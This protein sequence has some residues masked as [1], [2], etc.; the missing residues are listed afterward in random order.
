MIESAED[1][2]SV[3][4]MAI[5]SRNSCASAISKQPPASAAGKRGSQWVFYTVLA[6]LFVVAAGV[7]ALC[8]HSMSSMSEML[9]PGGWKM[10]MVWMRMPGQSWGD[11]MTSFVGMWVAMMVAMMLPSLAPTLWRYY[12]LLP[13]G[14]EASRARRIARIGLGYFF[15]WTLIG[16]FVFPLGIGVAAL[17]MKEPTLS[18]AVP[19]ATGV[20]V[21]LAGMLQ[22]TPWKAQHLNRCRNSPSRH[23]ELPADAA[24]ACKLGLRFGLHCSL[25]CANLTTVLL[26]LG[27]MDLRVMAAATVAITAERLAPAASP[28]S[29]GIGVAIACTGLYLIAAAA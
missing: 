5:T 17:E 18:R 29:R 9:M 20:V 2:E 10:S 11:A 28:I 27:V 24:A 12:Q 4:T 7:T 13:N 21:L 26:V 8:C 25:S 14:P 1:G 6:L 22:F 15:V 19:L 3:M 23:L 16:I